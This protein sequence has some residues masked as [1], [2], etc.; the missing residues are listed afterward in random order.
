[1]D[2]NVCKVSSSIDLNLKV[3]VIIIF[4]DTTY[5][6]KVNPD[7]IPTLD[8]SD[9]P[10][11]VPSLFTISF[12]N[13]EPT[14]IQCLSFDLTDSPGSKPRH[15]SSNNSSSILYQEQH[16]HQ[17]NFDLT[18]NNIVIFLNVLSETI[19]IRLLQFWLHLY[20]MILLPWSSSLCSQSLLNKF[21]NF[22]VIMIDSL[23]LFIS[24]FTILSGMNIYCSDI[25][26]SEFRNLNFIH[27]QFSP[28]YIISGCVEILS[29]TINTVYYLCRIYYVITVLL[30]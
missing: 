14:H 19:H 17:M 12:P 22:F 6:S 25:P 24:L 15:V 8:E 7:S 3:N 1:M 27:A 21:G 29:Y 4:Y 13:Y 5:E 28:I 26:S 10:D 30:P 9:N 23:T 20:D 16:E 18:T 2:S 11:I